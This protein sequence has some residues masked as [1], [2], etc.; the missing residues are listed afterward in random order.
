MEELVQSF[1]NEG[2]LRWRVVGSADTSDRILKVVAAQCKQHRR[3]ESVAC[4][5]VV[6]LVVNAAWDAAVV[7]LNAAWD[8]AVVVLNAAWD[9]AMLPSAP[10]ARCLRCVVA[11]LR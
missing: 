7:V 8:A 2:V 6:L 4:W 10:S 1:G 9:G 3:D 5:D 11:Q